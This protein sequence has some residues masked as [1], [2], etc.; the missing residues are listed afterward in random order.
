ML[1]SVIFKNDLNF[2]L[3]FL[4]AS[5]N[6][7]YIMYGLDLYVRQGPEQSFVSGQNS[8]SRKIYALQYSL[9]YC[10]IV[11]LVLCTVVLGVF[12]YERTST[13]QCTCTCICTS[14][15][16]AFQN[17]KFAI[18]YSTSIRIFKQTPSSKEHYEI[19]I[20]IMPSIAFLGN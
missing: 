9:K 3:N 6:D 20:Y 19:L 2:F 18:P 15:L 14:T 17:M 8:H 7:S 13:V 5:S 4:S 16:F 1:S 12:L 11:L 10:T